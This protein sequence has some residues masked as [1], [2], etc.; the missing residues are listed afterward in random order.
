MEEYD[1]FDSDNFLT[2][3]KKLRNP[4]KEEQE[5]MEEEYISLSSKEDDFEQ[6]D[7]MSPTV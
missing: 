5:R 2:S 4:L 3:A 7:V 1:V 6:Y